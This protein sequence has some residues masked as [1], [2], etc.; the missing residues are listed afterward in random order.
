MVTALG[1]TATQ[2]PPLV[3]YP[4]FG[5]AQGL[6]QSQQVGTADSAEFPSLE[7]AP[8]PF[9]GIEREVHRRAA[10]PDAAV[11]PPHAPARP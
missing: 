2:H 8:Q 6:A 7:I 3:A 1:N 5:A 9:D 4:L 10:A 11:W